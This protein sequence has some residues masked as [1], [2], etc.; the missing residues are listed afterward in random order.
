MSL[1]PV[2][3][4]NLNNQYYSKL[5]YLC[6]QQCISESLDKVQLGGEDLLYHTISRKLP[7]KGLQFIA[8][9]SNLASLNKRNNELPVWLFA[10]SV[11]TDLDI[12]FEMLKLEANLFVNA[13]NQVESFTVTSND[14]SQEKDSS[15]RST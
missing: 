9:D 13:C 1:L 10:A 8:E 14:A 7:W 5:C 6:L 4:I 12:I 2:Q 11:A 3:N 15:S